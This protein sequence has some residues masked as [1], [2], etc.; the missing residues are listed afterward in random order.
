MFTNLINLF[1]FQKITQIIKTRFDYILA[2]HTIL[3]PQ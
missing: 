2:K 1:T 3:Y